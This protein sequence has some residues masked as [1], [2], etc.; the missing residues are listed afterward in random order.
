MSS[1]RYCFKSLKTVALSWSGV[2]WLGLEYFK[3]IC[4]YT[5]HKEAL[6]ILFLCLLFSLRVSPKR[7]MT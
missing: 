5:M 2:L 1:G 6:N 7:L 4:T 3:L